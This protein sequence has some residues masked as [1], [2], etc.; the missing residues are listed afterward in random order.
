MLTAVYS[1]RMLEQVFW[2]DYGGFKVVIREHAKATA[3][4]ILVL[5]SLAILSLLSGYFFKDIFL[6]FGSVYFSQFIHNLPDGHLAVEAEFLPLEIKMLPSTLALL[7]FELESRFFECKW[8]YN[9][10]ANGYLALPTL[11]ISRHLF[12]QQEK[13]M[14]EQNGP[15]FIASLAG[16][17]MTDYF[18]K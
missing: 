6:G 12:E 13:I 7:A 10:I 1:F 18:K 15:L 11:I 17:A 14:L 9:E 3:A 5:A 16:R 4:E 8:F 2:A